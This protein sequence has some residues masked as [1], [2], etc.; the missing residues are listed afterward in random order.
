MDEANKVLIP[1]IS[2][3]KPVVLE[4]VNALEFDSF[5]TAL[6]GLF[7]AVYRAGNAYKN[8][9]PMKEVKKAIF[10]QTSLSEGQ[11]MKCIQKMIDLNKA[12]VSCG[13]FY[14]I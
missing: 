7:E 5:K 1:A 10:A 14:L 12:M 2:T 8:D 9:L 4:E 6:F 11:F 13:V 3:A